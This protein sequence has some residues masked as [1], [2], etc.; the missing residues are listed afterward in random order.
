M[1]TLIRTFYDVGHLVLAHG[2]QSLSFELALELWWDTEEVDCKGDDG[3][4]ASDDGKEFCSSH[5]ECRWSICSTVV[6]YA[7]NEKVEGR[8]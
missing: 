4:Y 8:E 7:G 6:V 1:N 5:V 2:L 3:D